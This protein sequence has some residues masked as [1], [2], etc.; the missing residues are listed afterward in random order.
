M[1]TMVL[2]TSKMIQVKGVRKEAGGRRVHH[3]TLENSTKRCFNF[4]FNIH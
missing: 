3:V 1:A 4:F 2:G